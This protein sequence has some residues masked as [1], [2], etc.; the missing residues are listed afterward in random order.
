MNGQ[1]FTDALRDDHETPLS[2]LGSS[3]WVYA[4]TGGE[5]DG[6]AVEAAW[7][8]ETAAAHA[9]FAAWADDEESDE[10]AA[11]FVD[12][13]ETAA[14]HGDGHGDAETETPP[15]YEALAGI[16]GTAERAGGL[17]AWTLVTEKTLAQLVGFFVGDADPSS[18]NT[19]RGYRSDLQDQGTTAADL[20]DTV[21]DDE[22]DWD[23]AREGA[24][25]VI[26][27]A[28]DD[29]VETLESMGIKPK[30]VC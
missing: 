23:A 8:T 11:A 16:E 14:G 12:V 7:A 30:N 1:E 5:M 6:D 27:A 25:R 26:E 10:A 17:L 4:L 20:L 15:M 24:D 21:C 28:Y 18:A 9:T 19:F 2:R 29:Y 13:A 3:K 22:T